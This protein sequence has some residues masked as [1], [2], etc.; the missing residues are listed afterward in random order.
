MVHAVGLHVSRDATV[1]V[2]P[3]AKRVGFAA[4]IARYVGVVG[5]SKVISCKGR[6]QGKITYN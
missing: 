2:E 4:V 6:Q 3:P 5:I 1:R